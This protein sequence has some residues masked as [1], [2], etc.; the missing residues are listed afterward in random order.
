MDLRKIHKLTVE[1]S[2]TMKL[3]KTITCIS[4]LA[5]PEGIR[6]MEQAFKGH[7][8]HGKHV[9]LVTAAIDE[10]INEKGYIVPGVGDAGDR[11]YA[12]A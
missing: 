9:T 12:T 5:S 11:L 4:L 2:L 3:F 6:A 1:G 10:G 7:E 8:D